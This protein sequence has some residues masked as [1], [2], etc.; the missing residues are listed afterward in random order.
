MLTIRQDLHERRSCGS[1]K[2]CTLTEMGQGERPP[3]SDRDES[4]PA[5]TAT[6]AGIGTAA[7]A[8]A[9]QVAS[10]APIDSARVDPACDTAAPEMTNV[11]TAATLP[12]VGMGE[13]GEGSDRREGTTA[14]APAAIAATL[15]S[16]A[17]QAPASLAA[18]LP[19]PAGQ[20]P[21]SLAATLPGPAGHGPTLPAMTADG[22][23]SA[24]TLEPPQPG[25]A[26]TLPGPY[27]VADLPTLPRVDDATYAIGAEIAR[28][29]MGKILSA[30]DRRLRR[31]V[32]IKVMRRDCGRIDPRFEREALITARL[33]HP[34]IVRVYDAGVLG[35]GR[36]FYAM[37]RVR[38]RSLEVVLEE[39]TTLRA[40]LALLPHALAV[41]DALAYA[42]SEGVVHR[43]LKPSNV[44]LG[45]FG[46]TVVIDWGL[47]KDLRA[48]EAEGPGAVP[49]PGSAHARGSDSSLTQHGAVMGTPAFMAPEQARGELADERTDIYALGALLYTML[50]GGPPHH[51]A[52][53][54]EVLDAVVAGKRVPIAEV[55]PELPAELATIVEH[56]MAHDR[57][58]R[59]ST[60]KELADELRNFAA[61]KLVA[62]HSYSTWHLVRRWIGRHRL[63]VGIATAAVVLL[64]LTGVLAVRDVLHERD[65]AEQA[66]YAAETAK[67]RFVLEQ[68][69]DALQEDPSRTAAWLKKLSDDALAWP[70]V[71][72]L[73]ESLPGAGL[74]RELIG[75]RQD[76]ELVASSVDGSHAVTG[77]DDATARWWNLATGGAVELPG[78]TGPI[79]WLALSSDGTYVATAGTDHVV[80]LWNLNT[81]QSK[82]LTG[83]GGTV[84][85][86]AFS[87]DNS[88]LASTAEDGTLWLWDVASGEGEQLAAHSH[89]LRPLV[90]FD[91]TT[92]LVGAFNGAL[93][94][95][96]LAAPRPLRPV[97]RQLHKAELRWI[98]VTPSREH[99][100]IGDEDG[101][102][103][104]WTAAGTRV[105][106]LTRHNDV[107]REAIITR[108]GR[109]VVS[110]GGDED[111][112]VVSLV[113]GAKHLLKGHE[114]GIKDIDVSADGSLVASAG[115]DGTVR[116]WRLDGTPVLVL[117]GHRAA[118]KSVALGP[119]RVLSGAEDRV[120][121][122]WP[123]TPAGPPP[124]GVALRGWLAEHTNVE[125]AGSA[126]APREP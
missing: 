58:A 110:A 32:V 6:L 19:G 54:D 107:A 57:H 99:V 121:R 66:R 15:P 20:A 63:P 9:A 12:G 2:P 14:Q 37:E 90:W 105:R 10:V 114:S 13:P 91:D 77:S 124:R 123:L 85:R 49:E 53:S 78:H 43:D 22:A 55:E 95:I 7:P 93:A 67:D 29:G 30:R 118:V 97:W 104:L 1:D 108:D 18:T 125:I 72:A 41:C 81:L 111:V 23:G 16:P 74:A 39:A 79:E 92:L 47:A 112:H 106:E 88:R 120:L 40:R 76:I 126:L 122:V 73:A 34:S 87:P 82:R 98:A 115:I 24:E 25:H 86:V 17:A 71:H 119:D 5:G 27:T 89:A 80:M 69:R 33:Q 45:P 94:R 100:V 35:D 116:V 96:D 50:T 102:L 75:H 26:A 64:A 65:I 52:S 51:G 62:S 8:D 42:H 28:G 101:S 4:R 56:A 61:G 38:G 83:H 11:G 109:H 31:E 21:A 84:R 70:E 46:E 59:Y 48:V 103:I 44:L 3:A 117:R 68:A 60:A 113:D 36:A